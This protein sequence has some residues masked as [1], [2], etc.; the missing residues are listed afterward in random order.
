MTA[1]YNTNDNS[2]RYFI[3]RDAFFC[4]AHILLHTGN[5]LIVGGVSIFLHDKCTAKS[6]SEVC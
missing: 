4:S 6:M 1:I 3:M 2:Y 5:V